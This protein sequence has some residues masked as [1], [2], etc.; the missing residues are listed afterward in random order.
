MQIEY[1]STEAGIQRQSI[2]SAGNT[3]TSVTLTGLRKF[4]RYEIQVLAYTRMGDGAPSTPEVSAK[5][6]PD[7]E[8]IVL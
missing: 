5:T 2:T 4:V 3:T 1:R 6:L 7:S 8:Y